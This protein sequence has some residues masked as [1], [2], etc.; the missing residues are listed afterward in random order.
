MYVY[1][2]SYEVHK[3]HLSALYCIICGLSG[4]TLFLHIILKQH[5]FLF[6]GGVFWFSV[7]VLWETLLILRQILWHIIYAQYIGLHIEYLLFSQILMK[8]QFSK[9]IFEKSS[10]ISSFMLI[11]PA[12][13]EMFP[14]NLN[15]CRLRDWHFHNILFKIKHKLHIAAG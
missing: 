11:H 10:Q 1:C 2:L 5:D 6:G 8:L 7:Q 9:Q 13:A 4:S 14:C 12:E 3:L 15:R